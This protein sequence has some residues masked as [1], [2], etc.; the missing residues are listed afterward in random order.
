MKTLTLYSDNEE[1][2]RLLQ[3]L[4]DKLGVQVR[5]EEEQILNADFPK[6]ESVAEVLRDWHQHG[7]LQTSISDPVAWQREQRKDRKL[8][9]RN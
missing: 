1:N 6:K 8:P 3:E 4:A 7:G 5:E 2:L 9:G